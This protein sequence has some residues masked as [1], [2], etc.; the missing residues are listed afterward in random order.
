MGPAPSKISW[1]SSW[2]S[3]NSLTASIAFTTR[4]NPSW[5][6]VS[7]NTTIATLDMLHSFHNEQV[8]VENSL[9][10]IGG[11][12][13]ARSRDKLCTLLRSTRKFCGLD[14]N[15]TKKECRTRE[16]PYRSAATHPLG[17]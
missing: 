4:P 8:N 5:V 16:V 6:S 11:T 2:A 15:C 7:A 17:S 1:T 10:L 13:A 12:A 9:R 14:Y 3:L